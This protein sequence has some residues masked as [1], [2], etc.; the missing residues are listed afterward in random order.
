MRRSP[1][2]READR[3]SGLCGTGLQAKSRR[4]AERPRLGSTP[5]FPEG[6]A[7]LSSS[8]R[9]SQPPPLDISRNALSNCARW[10]TAPSARHDVLCS[11]LSWSRLECPWVR[12]PTS[13]LPT[14]SGVFP[15][16]VGPMT[17]SCSPWRQRSELTGTSITSTAGPSIAR[18]WLADSPSAAIGDRRLYGNPPRTPWAAGR[19]AN[20]RCPRYRPRAGPPVPPA[21][22]P[23][24]TPTARLSTGCPPVAIMVSAKR[25]LMATI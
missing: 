17:V 2:Q 24:C 11:A 15:E 21:C 7:A 22:P 9:T 1:G 6:A 8:R 25:R 4:L 12:S 20:H 10:F 16:P 14:P 19:P 13:R 3:G 23:L 18:S 5:E